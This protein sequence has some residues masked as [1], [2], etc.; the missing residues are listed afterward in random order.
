MLLIT[1]HENQNS[2]VKAYWEVAVPSMHSLRQN[3]K[4][5]SVPLILTDTPVDWSAQPLA[6][7]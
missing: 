2:Y 3:T 7:P 4:G 1:Q 5:V 6:L